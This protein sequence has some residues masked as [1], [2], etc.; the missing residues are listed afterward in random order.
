MSEDKNYAVV[1]PLLS[2]ARSRGDLG[3]EMIGG[4]PSLEHPVVVVWLPEEVTRERRQ[5]SRLR[6]ETA[7][8]TDLHHP[9]IIPIYGLEH[10][11]QGWARVV[12]YIDGEPLSRVM[13]LSQQQDQ[14]LSSLVVARVMVDVCEAVH[15]AHEYG[16]RNIAGRAI[17]HGGLRPDTVHL[18]FDG[19]TRVT[20]YGAS[21]LAPRGPEA[22]YVRPY[23]APEQIIGGLATASLT[24]DVYGIGALLYALVT[25]HPPFD[26]SKN[27]DAMV[28]A[29][30]ERLPLEGLLMALQ[31]LAIEAMAKS[32]ADRIPSVLVF[33]KRIETLIEAEGLSLPSYA[34][35]GAL[36]DAL[37]AFDAPERAGRMEM[38]ETAQ[39]TGQLLPLVRVPEGSRDIPSSLSQLP[40]APEAAILPTLRAP[41]SSSTVPGSAARAERS[42]ASDELPQLASPATS[43]APAPDA[44]LELAFLPQTE[45]KSKSSA[46]VEPVRG[47]VPDDPS[48]PIEAQ[49]T[50]GIALEDRQTQDV[51][52]AQAAVAVTAPAPAQMPAV[53]LSQTPAPMVGPGAPAPAQAVLQATAPLRAQNSPALERVAPG[54]PIPPA[55]VPARNWEVKPSLSPEDRLPAP[56]DIPLTSPGFDPR[57]QVEDPRLVNPP[58]AGLE[59][60]PPGQPTREAS[61]MISQFD[62]RRGDGSRYA[63]FLALGALIAAVGFYFFFP[64]RVPEGLSDAE[65]TRHTLPKDLVREAL[66]KTPAPD[67]EEADDEDDTEAAE[68]KAAES[69]KKSK[70]A[71]KRE[72]KQPAS[73]SVA[74]EPPV[75]IYIKGHKKGRTPLRL[76]LPAG[77]HKLRLTDA[78]TRINTYRTVRLRS[79]QSKR[80][81]FEFGTS[82]LEVDAPAGA[83]ISLNRRVVGRAPMTPVTIYEGNYLLEVSFQGMSWKQRFHAPPNQRIHYDVTLQ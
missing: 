73:L 13:Q 66:T 46:D 72:P 42:D 62:M 55:P 61:S 9:N 33:K 69:P 22:K 23:M 58:V 26:A 74:S 82:R 41:R 35:V 43:R 77:R 68:A 79:G 70:S 8:V 5:L 52:D 17:V 34:T 19:R 51:K 14:P 3:C 28:T 47:P 67:P 40:A 24:T 10:F 57:R 2:G 49:P 20:G 16:Q 56:G 36:V 39:K 6:R 32:G 71:A 76:S 18:C 4:Q 29:M 83:R 7:F 53:A 31:D 11:E 63:L 65:S 50:A 27:A 75:D 12:G 15:Y 64:N 30:P 37:I 21:V 80:L 38:L 60:A 44:G 25:G 1:G 45:S 81:Q 48:L 78:K 54:D 59:P